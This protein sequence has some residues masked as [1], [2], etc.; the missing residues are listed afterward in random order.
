MYCVIKLV[1]ETTS[2]Y[3]A[4][5]FVSIVIGFFIYVI[6]LLVL[7]EKLVIMFLDSAKQ[8]IFKVKR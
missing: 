5:C 4:H 7:R 1:P 2:G 6:T 8:K 3:F